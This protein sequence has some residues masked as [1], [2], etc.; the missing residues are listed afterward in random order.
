MVPRVLKSH[1]S[2]VC[3]VLSLGCVAGGTTTWSCCACF[4]HIHREGLNLG[5]F[6]SSAKKEWTE[7]QMDWSNGLGLQMGLLSHEGQEMR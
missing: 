2:A 7:Y 5:E 4:R 1:H 3:Q 6:V